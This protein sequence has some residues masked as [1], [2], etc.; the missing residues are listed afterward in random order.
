MK[1][2]SITIPVVRFT[3]TK[4]LI[5]RPNTF[6]GCNLAYQDT[7]TDKPHTD[8]Y[9]IG[10]DSS[11]HSSET[12]SLGMTEL[13]TYDVAISGSSRGSP[14]GYYCTSKYY[15][16]SYKSGCNANIDMPDGFTEYFGTEYNGSDSKNRVHI[17][18]MGNMYSRLMTP[19]V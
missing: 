19:T 17:G 6:K 11:G 2:S 12:F 7:S 18:R 4:L 14:Y 5:S 15:W 13:P 1:S 3:I 16:N 9:R 10:T 8:N